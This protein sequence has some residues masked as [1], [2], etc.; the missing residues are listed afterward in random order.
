MNLLKKDILAY[1]LS[2]G[3]SK[4]AI[5]S[6]EPFSKDETFLRQWL[7]D[8][9][10]G[11][12]EYLLK[13]AKVRGRPQ[14]LLSGAKSIIVLA[15]NYYQPEGQQD[16]RSEQRDM[17]SERDQP[18]LSSH[19][20][21]LTDIDSPLAARF[22][23]PYRV[24]R[25]SVGKDYHT[26]I[27]KRLESL[28]RYIEALA[29]E[30]QSRIFI[31]TGPLLERAAAQRGGLGFVGKNTMVI[32]KGFGS[33]IFLASVVTTLDLPIDAPD[34]RTCG[35]CTLCIDA[36][37]TGALDTPYQMDP[38]KCIAYL[39]IEHRSPIPEPLRKPIGS[40]LFGCDICQEVCPHNTRPQP[41]QIPEFAP[42]SPLTLEEILS[43]S[44]DEEFE[45]H[46]RGMPLYR[47]KRE[48]LLRNACIVAANTGRIDL[49]PLLEKQAANDRSPLV[50]ETARWALLELNSHK[51]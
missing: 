38:R 31:D 2:L 24:A 11:E 29:P 7:A 46:F 10:A 51:F 20:L 41:T 30:S 19:N 12:M 6:A 36:C 25:Y 27:R 40:W 34:L 9:R 39:T 50:Q 48:G 5:A 3:F 13:N 28:I 44:T 1:S 21:P 42:L 14:E 23:L 35:T 49:K 18:L 32:S 47:T 17:R 15:M 43:I 33:W 4:A 8:G 37:P 22:S 45:K 16:T 26:V